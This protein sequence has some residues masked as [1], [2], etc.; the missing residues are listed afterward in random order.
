MAN[1]DRPLGFRPVQ[2]FAGGVHVRRRKYLMEDAYAGASLFKGDP[3]TPDASMRPNIATAST[4]LLG[5]FAGCEY[6][7]TSGDQIYSDYWPSGTSV[8]S[9][10][11]P[12][13]FIWDDPFTVF[14]VQGSTTLGALAQTDVGALFDIELT[15]AGSTTSGQSGAEMGVA[16]DQLQLLRIIDD[17][18]VRD[19]NG[20]QSTSAVGTNAI[21]W[22][23][24]YNHTLL[25]ATAG[26]AA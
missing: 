18:P 17:R 23:R 4:D 2:H 7:N 21:C 14:E 11:T 3:I 8:Q 25:G 1:P 20:N 19:S 22:V 15:H 24:I 9:G 12:V 5:I 6:V 26:V 13:A 16:G 10:T